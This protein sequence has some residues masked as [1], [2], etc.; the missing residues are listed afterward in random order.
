MTARDL[1]SE[2]TTIFLSGP[3]GAGKTTLAVQRMRALL[4][5]SAPGD[6][7]IVFA[8]QRSL[9]RPYQDQLERADLPPGSRPWLLTIGGL[10]RQTVDLFWPGVAG[11][12]GFAHP[13]EPPV[14]LTLETAQYYMAR[15]VEPLIKETGYFE[16]VRLQ[17]PRLYSQIL[18]NLN[19]A[20]L[21]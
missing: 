11:R 4:A 20:A 16:S 17:H 13:N 3:A 21:V 6:S 1:I 15:V 5:A 8:P 14:F 7:I 9:L 10:A 2:R 19:K 12:A 18:D